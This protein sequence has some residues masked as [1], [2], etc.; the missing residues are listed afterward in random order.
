MAA[1]FLPDLVEQ[2]VG[3]GV[4]GQNKINHLLVF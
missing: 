3:F 1:P 2:T 4:H